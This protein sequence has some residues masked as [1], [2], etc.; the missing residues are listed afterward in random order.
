MLNL[1]G[2]PIGTR[3]DFVE[4]AFVPHYENWDGNPD[5]NAIEKYLEQI[6][7]PSLS[8]PIKPLID[9]LLSY[10][11]NPVPHQIIKLILEKLVTTYHSDI[12]F[13]EVTMMTASKNI[14]TSQ[15]TM[16]HL[17]D[18]VSTLQM[19]ELEVF[20]STKL[21]HECAKF[22]NINVARA[23]IVKYPR[24]LDSCNPMGMR[25][26]HAAFSYQNQSA[27]RSDMVRLLLSEGT[28]HDIGGPNGCGGVFLQ[29]K[30]R[31]SNVG[32]SPIELA[33]YYLRQKIYEEDCEN[34][35]ECLLACVDVIKA[36]IPDFQ[37]VNYLIKLDISMEK[38]IEQIVNRFD[39]DLNDTDSSGMTPLIVAI[40]ERKASYIRCLLKIQKCATEAIRCCEVSGITYRNCLPLHIAVNEGITWDD[41]M[42]E[43]L[44]ANQLASGY[45]DP[46]TGLFPF[47]VAAQWK[48][49]SLDDMFNLLQSNPGVVESCIVVKNVPNPVRFMNYLV[50]I[51]VLIGIAAQ[52]CLA[53]A[54]NW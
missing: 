23:I 42:K 24:A 13:D 19:E 32:G 36:T 16:L 50:V 41:G 45:F 30:S 39:I 37:L 2:A 51:I 46:F 43:I 28:K 40:Q 20:V 27:K 26:I 5:W 52:Y 44:Q 8:S 33:L 54:H 10:E 48:N 17:L 4:N 31:G 25:P 22:N 38:L 9:I 7:Q 11:D 21:I 14:Y 18:Q 3:F 12:C 29:R 53:N 47:M 34:E 6:E 49:N 35:W 1:L 15:Q